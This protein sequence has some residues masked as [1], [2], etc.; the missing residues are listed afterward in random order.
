MVDTNGMCARC[1]EDKNVLHS[2]FGYIC[3]DCIKDMQTH[4]KSLLPEDKSTRCG[5]N[6]FSLR[7]GHPF[8]KACAKHDQY[9]A[10]K[11]AGLGGMTRNRADKELLKDM[12][13]IAKIRG[14]LILKIEAYIFWALAR[15][16]GRPLW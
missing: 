11:E 7:K 13:S 12:L 10:N 3:R 14:S 9:F 5:W 1:R 6:V 8:E 16:F 15:T 2:E 4:L